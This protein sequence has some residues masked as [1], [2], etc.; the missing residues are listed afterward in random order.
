MTTGAFTLKIQ[1]SS[2]PFSGGSSISHS[3]YRGWLQDPLSS[4]RSLSSHPSFSASGELSLLVRRIPT[5]LVGFGWLC[6]P[7]CCVSG[8]CVFYV[9]LPGVSRI[10]PN[11]C[12]GLE[13]Q[14]SR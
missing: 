7:V 9:N 4:L 10:G 12:N 11:G 13:C 6:F 14:R 1:F 2:K 5:L 3:R 8:A